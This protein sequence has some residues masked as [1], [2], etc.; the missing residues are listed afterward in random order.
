MPDLNGGPD[1]GD[2]NEITKNLTI[3]VNI[4]HES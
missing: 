3:K 4:N 1:S 2:F